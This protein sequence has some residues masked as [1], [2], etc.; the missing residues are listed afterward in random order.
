MTGLIIQPIIGYFSDRTWTKWDEENLLL[1]GAILA[2]AA[3]F[4]MPNSRFVV[5][6]WNA[7]DHGRLHQCSWNH[8]AFVGDNLPENNVPWDLPCK[9]FWDWRLLRIKTTLIFTIRSSK[10]SLVLFRFS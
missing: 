9:V 10:Y 1:A 2:S 5:C 8:F 6:G 7:L 3:L 4:I